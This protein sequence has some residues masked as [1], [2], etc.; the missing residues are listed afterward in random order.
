MTDSTDIETYDEDSTDLEPT[1]SGAISGPQDDAF[2]PIELYDHMRHRTNGDETIVILSSF[3]RGFQAIAFDIDKA[4]EILDVEEIGDAEDKQSA[5]S[6]CE[7]WVQQHPKGILG[8]TEDDEDGGGGF[9]EALGF[10][11]GGQ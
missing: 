3:G 4:G 2:D 6:M 7:Y 11:G 8:G 10:G 5:E 9:L 1:D